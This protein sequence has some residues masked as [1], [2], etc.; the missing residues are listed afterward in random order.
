MRGSSR[1]AGRRWA[2]A[3]LK[4]R[5]AG[6]GAEIAGVR[7]GDGVEDE[8]GVFHAAGHRAELV[9]RPAE[10]HGTGAGDAAEGGAEASDSAT[11]GRVNDAAFGFTADGEGDESGGGGGAGA[12]AGAACAFFF[13]CPGVH[14]LA[15]EP[16]VIEGERAHAEFGD[17]DG[18]GFVEAIDDNGV[19]CGNAIAEGLGAIGSAD[20]R[21][22]EQIFSAPGDAVE[23]VRDTFRRRFPCR[24]GGLAGA[25]ARG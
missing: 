9:E 7:T 4:A 1:R 19:F 22:V 12:C 23:R 16:D 18:S 21:G 20:A 24:P 17:E 25:R 8:H 11:H 14:G 15:A 10:G 5:C 2:L 3:A 6:N 13:G